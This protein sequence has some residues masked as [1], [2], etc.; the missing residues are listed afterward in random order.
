MAA[1]TKLILLL[2]PW[3]N[4][5]L[6]FL[7]SKVYNAEGT[8]WLPLPGGNSSFSNSSS[9][10]R[11]RQVNFDLPSVSD[12]IKNFVASQTIKLK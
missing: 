5:W 1:P 11:T 7:N 3:E 6:L 4:K 2:L 10:E 12:T 8:P 9:M